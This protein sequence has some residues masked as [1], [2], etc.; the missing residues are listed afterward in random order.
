MITAPTEATP[1]WL[2]DALCEAGVLPHGEVLTIEFQPTGAFNSA[3]MRLIV[4]YSSDVLETMPRAF[5]LKCSNGTE[6]GN[7][8]NRDEVCFYR[9][10]ASLPDYPPLMVPCYSTAYDEASGA[11]HLLLLDLSP[12]HLVPVPRE[13]QIAIEKGENVPAQIYIERAVETLAAL[14]AYWWEHE[15]LGSAVFPMGYDDEEF[16]RYWSSRREA[17]AWLRENE[18]AFLTPEQQ[19]LCEE[20]VQHFDR[21]WVDYLAPRMREKSR[22]T[23]IHGDAYFANMLSPRPGIVGNTYLIDWQSAEPHLGPFDLVNLC[24]TF[25]TREQRQEGGREQRVLRHYL[26]QLQ[27]RGVQNYH[28][29]DLLLDYRLEIIEWLLITVRDAHNGSRRSYWQPKLNC[30]TAAFEDWHCLD[31]LISGAGS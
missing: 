6:W 26:A 13:Q 17:V 16:A 10:T 22:L 8:A 7:Q 19:L 29:E 14:H 2:S 24:A 27:Q 9:F 1:T 30:M 11:S 31:L 4:T 20:T 15:L 5:I 12:T 21:W 28:W 18:R 3:T 23:L 25:W